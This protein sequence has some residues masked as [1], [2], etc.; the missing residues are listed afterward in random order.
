METELW[1]KEFL[2]AHGLVFLEN[3]FNCKV[4]EIDLIMQDATSIQPQ[5]LVFVEVRYRRG[6]RYGGAS[7]SVTPA[8]QRRIQKAAAVF[9]QA[10]KQFQAWPMRFDVVAMEGLPDNLQVSWLK[11][12]FEC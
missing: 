4:G 7:V 8:K 1:A 9:C 3:N 2:I 6:K 12:A 11:S 5:I 10:R